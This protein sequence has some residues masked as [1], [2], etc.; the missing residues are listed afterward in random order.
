MKQNSELFSNYD[1]RSIV[2]ISIKYYDFCNKLSNTCK[3]R[4]HK[5]WAKCTIGKVPMSLYEYHSELKAES[6]LTSSVGNKKLTV[7]IKSHSFGTQNWRLQLWRDS[8]C[9]Q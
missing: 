1:S 8:Q 7:L 5:F 6:K 4:F 3:L 9:M 2:N